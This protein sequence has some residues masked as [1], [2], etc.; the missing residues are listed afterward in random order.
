MDSPDILAVKARLFDLIMHR[1]A[2]NAE[3]E[4]LMLQLRQMTDELQR[5]A[6]PDTDGTATDNT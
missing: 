5:Q 2:I 1:D 4:R 3:L 6:V